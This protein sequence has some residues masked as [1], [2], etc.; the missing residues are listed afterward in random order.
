M[1]EAIL[2]SIQVGRVKPLG[3]R[4]VPSAFAKHAIDGPVAVTPLGLAGDDQADLRVHGGPDKAVYGYAAAHLSAWA[5]DYPEHRAKFS[6]GGVGENLTIGGM[7][8][9]DLCVGDIH[10]IGS[11]VLQ[12]C[13]ARQP[14]FKFALRFADSRLP[15]AMVHN[16]RAGWYYRVI[17]PGTIAAG[18]RV[19][20]VER[21]HPD[22][23]FARLIE[24]GNFHDATKSE[25]EAMAVMDGLAVVLRDA[26]RA[27]LATG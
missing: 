22:F 1:G 23:A 12:I 7:V 19:A 3:P 16:R 20:L 6:A 26:A 15:K 24:I 13:Q 27:A 8:D 10:R 2:Q 9:D 17:E 14:C 25:L 11:A 5:A 21:S 18:D 4:A